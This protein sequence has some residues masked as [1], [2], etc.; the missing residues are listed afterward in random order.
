M[1]YI[2]PLS[3][4]ILLFI[5]LLSHAQNDDVIEKLTSFAASANIFANYFPQEKVYLHFDNTSYYIGDDIWFKCYVVTSPL[6][7][8]TL[9]SKTL[10]V[11][12]L[13]PDG[14]VIENKLL[15]IENGQCNGNFILNKRLMRGGFYE[16]RAYTKYML[17]FDNSYLFS[18]VFPVYDKPEK[19][20]DYSARNMTVARSEVKKKRKNEKEPKDVNISFYPEG[21][22]LVTGVESN[23]GFV[24]TDK[25]GA[26]IGVRGSIINSRN[27]EVTQF[28]TQHNGMGQFTLLPDGNTYKAK[29]EYKGNSYTGEL[30]KSKQTG[31]VLHIDNSQKDSISVRVTK[32]GSTP[33]QMVGLV[34]MSR[35]KLGTFNVLNMTASNDERL[36][37]PVKKHAGG[38]CQ[39]I[40]FDQAGKILA[41]RMFF[42][43]YNNYLSIKQ[44]QNK[45]NY[46]PY[47]KVEMDFEIN[48]K[49]NNSVETVFSL[50]VRDADNEME[51]LYQ[52]NILTN[53]L[54]SSDI[55]GYIDNPSYYFEADDEKHRQDLDLLLMTQ[56]WS[57]Y[58]WKYIT[59]AEPV[60]PKY[61]PEQGVLIDGT[62]TSLTMKRP[63]PNTD[64]SVIL[65][66]AADSVDFMSSS[67]ITDSLGKFKMYADITGKW[68][69]V[70]QTKEKDKNKKKDYNI[71]L[72]SLFSPDP[73]PYKFKDTAFTLAN[74][75]NKAKVSD[76]FL[77]GNFDEV[78]ED[79]ITLGIDQ[80]VHHLAGVEITEKAL[81]TIKEQDL[82]T[83]NVIYDAQD[84]L[85]E[86]IDKGEY[87]GEDIYEYL[88]KINPNFRIVR[89]GSAEGDKFYY[90]N[91]AVR[92][93]INNRPIL[94]GLYG[95]EIAKLLYSDGDNGMGQAG[96]NQ[97]SDVDGTYRGSIGVSDIETVAI[98]ESLGTISK[99]IRSSSLNAENPSKF[100]AV[101]FLYTLPGDVYRGKRAGIRRTKI[102][103]YALSKE[104][105]GPDYELLPPE[106]DYRRTLYWN[107]NVKTDS[108]GKAK[109]SFYNNST[110]R[111]MSISAE[112]IT[113]NGIPGVYTGNKD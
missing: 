86:I 93:V 96:N 22:N 58:E 44:S 36:R 10:H 26:Q 11:E 9:L 32:N 68:V 21:G 64:L 108:S 76:N 33:S 54:L 34:S 104:F 24:A 105:Y 15:K 52:D 73:R 67:C 71:L 95:E 81:N 65:S 77:P 72:N 90:K 31:Y 1:K 14:E 63:R 23:I 74:N 112:T 7:K 106:P 78:P 20:G 38:V 87:V 97:Y 35:D 6:T 53:L 107:P 29:I 88:I 103:G 80:R 79:S 46:A 16:I 2:K 27:E 50:S 55:K 94:G 59:G 41:E 82:A 75:V 37:I 62:V 40:L 99:Y 109:I 39:F 17:N 57:R 30:P 25:D 111:S 43:N 66:N 5:S 45:S 110:C 13:T 89:S 8:P 84:K 102:D 4:S 92:F 69:A 101:V 3:I 48:D 98:S 113:D 60:N 18:R 19:E 56:G 51:P 70:L 47:E 28:S 49:L 85:D 42:V 83:A 100:G 61:E 91:R 12:L